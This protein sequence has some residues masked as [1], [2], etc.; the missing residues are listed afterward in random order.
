MTE[1]TIFN[2]ARPKQDQVERAAY[3]D[4]ACAQ[5]R[6]MRERVALALTLALGLG[7][8]AIA[9]ACRGQRHCSPVSMAAFAAR[10]ACGCLAAVA[11][12]AVLNGILVAFR[13]AAFAGL[14]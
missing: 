7:L 10:F 13:L 9:L 11:L 4:E 8:S 3:L 12:A 5:D 2:V 1:E 6:A 14:W